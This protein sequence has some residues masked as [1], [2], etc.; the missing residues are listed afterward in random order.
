[1]FQR[2]AR[3]YIP[4]GRALGENLISGSLVVSCVHTDGRT[5]VICKIANNA[6][7]EC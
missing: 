1:M 2:T 4:E 6:F 5:N 3:R 7:G